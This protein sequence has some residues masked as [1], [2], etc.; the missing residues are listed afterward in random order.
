MTDKITRLPEGLPVPADLV[1][2]AEKAL[3]DLA[4]TADALDG[5]EAMKIETAD[6]EAQASQLVAAIREAINKADKARRALV[7]PIKDQTKLVDKAF[8]EHKDRLT[9]ISKQVR[10]RLAERAEERLEAEQRAQREAIAAAKAEDWEAANEAVSKDIPEP[11]PAKVSTRWVWEIDALELDKIPA[12]FLM[13]D[14]D[15]VKA[16]VK[17]CE[18][19]GIDPKIPGITFKRKAI[20]IVRS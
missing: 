2:T 18:A 6:H 16:H 15:K 10:Q 1:G 14:M 12:M 7:K 3:Q 17:A 5:L 13:I 4:D 11:A 9:K 20:P 19:E 8:K